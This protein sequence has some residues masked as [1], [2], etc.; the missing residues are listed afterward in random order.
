VIFAHRGRR[1]PDPHL[2]KKVQLFFAAA[3]V[4]LVG[5]ALDSFWLVGL[6]I[7]FLLAGL[8]LRFLPGG[9][10]AGGDP[11]PEGEESIVDEDPEPS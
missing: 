9:G 7:L 11:S 1:G 6:A 8:A 10:P 2:P 3:A 4:A 5:I